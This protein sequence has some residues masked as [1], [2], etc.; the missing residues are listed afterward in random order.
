MYYKCLSTLEGMA[1]PF[2]KETWL[3]DSKAA[4]PALEGM[5]PAC[6]SQR[7]L[8]NLTCSVQGA[9]NRGKKGRLWM[10]TKTGMRTGKRARGV[11]RFTY[12]P[13]S[14]SQ[15]FSICS[16]CRCF[17]EL[18]SNSSISLVGDSMAAGSHWGWG[19]ESL[20]SSFPA[21]SL[22][23]VQPSKS[24]SHFVTS[25]AASPETA[26]RGLGSQGTPAPGAPW[27]QP[28][29]PAMMP[30]AARSRDRDRAVR[31]SGI[32]STSGLFFFPLNKATEAPLEDLEA[33][34]ELRS[35]ES[36]EKVRSPVE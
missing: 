3:R 6:S 32:E 17:R 34:G 11:R 20:C 27:R 1:I 18:L 14:R 16:G 26:Q 25:P 12:S 7:Q 23:W 21:S 31:R 24:C 4:L 29:K 33:K 2:P 10:C 30:A 8:W 13:R 9:C 22:L 19:G 36:G 15:I 5:I 35:K 28:R